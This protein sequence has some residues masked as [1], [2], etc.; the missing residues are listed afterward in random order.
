[1]IELYIDGKR[2]DI[3]QD[4]DIKIT[5]QSADVKEPTAI[6]NSFSKSLNLDGTPVNNSIFGHCY[7]LDINILESDSLNGVNFD[8]R[9]RVPFDL[10]NNGEIIE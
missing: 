5:Y 10:I 1:M 7:R 2:A 4:S 6:K 3:A 9:K 8:P